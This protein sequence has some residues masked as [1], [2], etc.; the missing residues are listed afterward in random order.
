MIGRAVVTGGAGFIGSHLVT[1]LVDDG[2]EVLVIDDLSSGRLERLAEAR[3]AGGVHF[4]QMDIRAAEIG[5][6]V[7]QFQPEVLFHHAAQIDV[8]H[9]VAD[10]VHDASVNVVGTVNVLQAAAD[11]GAER[12]IFASSGGATFGD[13][14]VF[15][16]PETVPRRPES[17]YGVSK[18]IADDYLRYFKSA[19]NLDFVSLGYSNVYGP[20]QDPHGEAGVVAIFTMKLLSGETPT[21]FGD[22]GQLRDY[23]YV[24]D[25]ADACIRA[26]EIGGGLYLNIGTGRETSVLELFEMLKKAVGVDVEPEFASA[27]PGDIARSLLDASAA[28]EHLGWEAWTS[29]EDGLAETVAWFRAKRS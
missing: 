22:G 12:V 15:P 9:S 27:K 2:A 10:P 3:A 17:P 16:T 13:V 28:K 24:E 5:E 18:K 7:S 6:V 4:H 14:D 8:R 26:A 19:A 29:L 23:V 1:R 20:R 21:I 11:A 25:V